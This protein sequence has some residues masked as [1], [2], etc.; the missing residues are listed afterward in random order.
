MLPLLQAAGPRQQPS[1]AVALATNSTVR[2]LVRM[3]CAEESSEEAGLLD[4]ILA[5]EEFTVGRS[6]TPR[7]QP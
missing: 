7:V 3:L 6:S 2:V 4:A 1:C 5:A